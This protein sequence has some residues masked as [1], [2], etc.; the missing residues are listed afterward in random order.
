MGL[1]L[2]HVVGIGYECDEVGAAFVE[3]VSWSTM[4]LVSHWLLERGRQQVA[5]LHEKWPQSPHQ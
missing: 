5:I 4:W 2:V 1:T 3:Q